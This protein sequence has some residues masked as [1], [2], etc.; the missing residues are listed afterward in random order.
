MDAAI[1]TIP[2]EKMPSKAFSVSFKEPLF[3]DRREVSR[4]YTNT[5]R[6]GYSMEEL[7]LAS[8]LT[9]INGNDL[10]AIPR[11][12]LQYLK[13]MP[14]VDGQYLLAVFLS[15][16]TLDNELSEIA[17]SHGSDMKVSLNETHTI[18]RELMPLQEF[19]VTFRTPTLGD[20]MD[21]DRR[22]PGADSNCGYSLE[23]ML[24][25]HS[26]LAV[27]GEAITE[28]PKD[29]ITLL[30]NWKHLD[31]QF[32]MAIFMNAVTIDNQD[33][34]DA[35]SLGKSLRGELAKVTTHS[36][37]RSANKSPAT[38]AAA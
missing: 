25:A 30:D 14:H 32:A 12:P 34:Q 19:S 27:N 10:P 2:A 22:Y 11:D 29:V 7:L 16:F 24:F 35:K 3:K 26:L 33:S 1:F 28:H 13:D 31:A 17:K 21:I 37:K 15:M 4:R 8:C 5:T 20:R 36:A 9:G 38:T 23:E 6:V 18:A